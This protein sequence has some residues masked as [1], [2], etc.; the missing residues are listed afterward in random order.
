MKYNPT[1]IEALNLLDAHIEKSSVPS[2]R[3]NRIEYSWVGSI[4]SPFNPERTTTL[5][6]RCHTRIPSSSDVIVPWQQPCDKHLNILLLVQRERKERRQLPLDKKRHRTTFL[7]TLFPV[8]RPGLLPSS[9]KAEATTRFPMSSPMVTTDPKQAMMKIYAPPYQVAPDLLLHASFSNTYAMRTEAGLLLIDPGT[10][11]N[12]QSVYSAVRA[13]SQ[14]PLHTVD[15]THGDADH[16]FGLRAF[17]DA[18]ES[19]Q[20]IA[21]ENCPRHFQRYHLTKGYLTFINRRQT[22]NPTFVFPDRYD[23]P[24]SRS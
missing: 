11:Q 21:Q 18:G 4:R 14:A 16:A 15:Y 5:D 7:S 1:I 17:L 8:F 6:W 12:S 20:I 3:L 23:W 22:G 9:R 19:P 2:R 13:W 10:T 24:T